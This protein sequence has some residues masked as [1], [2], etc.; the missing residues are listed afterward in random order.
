MAKRK[1]LVLSVQLLSMV[2]GFLVL[3]ALYGCPSTPNYDSSYYD[4]SSAVSASMLYVPDGS[5]WK[6]ATNKAPFAKRFFHTSVVFN[7]MMWV[8]GGRTSEKV[9]LNDV[10]YVK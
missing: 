8:I 4:S 10:W 9:A 7:D 5:Q 6:C 2:C 3:L 1:K